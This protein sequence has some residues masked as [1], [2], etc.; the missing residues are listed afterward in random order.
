[1]KE[2]LQNYLWRGDLWV[3]AAALAA[4]LIM[5]WLFRGAPPGQSVDPED[6]AD[7]PRTGARERTIAVLVVGMM[8]IIGGCYVLIAHNVLWSLPVFALGFGLVLYQNARNRRYRHASPSLRRAIDLSTSLLNTGL[9]AGILIVVNVILFRYCG[10]PI[11]MTREGTYT[12]SSLTLNQ[13]STLDR[14][15]TFTMVFGRG[16]RASRQLER[17]LQL[18]ET[19]RV[20]NPN[21]I[22]LARLDPFNDPTGY[23]DL[24]KRIPELELLQGGGVVIEYGKGDAAQ[25][26]VVRNPDLFQQIP[27]DQARG[28]L[29]HYASTFSGED[30]ITSALIRM[31]EGKKAKVAFTTMHGELATSDMNPRGPGIGF[32]KARLSKVGCEVI[33]LNL[34]DEIPSDLSLLI[35]AGP[36]SAFKHDELLKLRA[37]SDRGGPILILLGNTEPTGLDEFL[38]SFNLALGT[39]VVVDGRY[40]YNK[41]AFLVYAFTRSGIQ[42]PIVDPLGPNHAVLMPAAAP[43][44][45]LGQ[46]PAAGAAPEPPVNPDLVPVPILQTSAYAWAESDPKS[47]PM[48]LDR[49]TDKQG[50]LILGV[51]VAERGPERNRPDSGVGGKPRLVLISCPG[52]A[53]NFFQDIHRTNLD[54]LMNAAS[55]LRGRADTQGIAPQAHVA[56]TLSVDPYLGSRLILVPSVVS[57]LLICAMGV[58][59][60][61][62]RRE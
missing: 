25:Y 29:D 9:L 37:Y 42:H 13:L 23:E 36:R 53:G 45:V 3:V 14:P 15:V 39:G 56:L 8:L 41:N 43:L 26:V 34:A 7:A 47:S 61:T 27:L 30:E 18:L 16:I 49:G 12:L 57:F 60:Y 1:M 38:K 5:V 50:P 32:W 55:W 48:R 51:A 2:A 59:V 6:D 33:D 35:V 4:F 28:G 21:F 58:I 54:L 11:D 20:A 40:C 10:R 22:T 52:M 19:Y 46:A 24:A 62:L 44:N 17:V 31:R